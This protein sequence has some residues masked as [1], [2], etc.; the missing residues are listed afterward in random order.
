LRRL[1]LIL[2]AGCGNTAI[3]TNDLSVPMDDLSMAADL[4]VAPDLAV[5]PDLAVPAEAD[6]ATL[7]DLSVAADFAIG[8]DFSLLPDL[9]EPDLSPLADLAGPY[10][11]YVD[12][13]A[14]LDGNPGTLAL[15]FKTIGAAASHAGSGDTIRLL[16]GTW[17]SAVESGFG[18]SGVTI[19]DGVAVRAV[20]PGTVTLA[21][22]LI[23]AGGGS[24]SDL[25]FQGGTP[26]IQASAGTLTLG[27]LRFLTD[28]DAGSLQITGTAAVSLVPGAAADYG[29]VNAFAVVS[30]GASLTVTGGKLTGIVWN[31]VDA[32]PASFRTSANATLTLD[33]VTFDT[34]QV[35]AIAASGVS[36]VFTKN[37]TVI[38]NSSRPTAAAF[39]TAAVFAGGAATVDIQGT[40]IINNPAPAIRVG[41]ATAIPTI[42]VRSVS[43][44]NNN[45]Y[46]IYAPS[47]ARPPSVTLANSTFDNNANGGVILLSGTEALDVR[48]CTFIG[49]HVNQGLI[50]Y[51]D[52]SLSPTIYVRG[53][54]FTGNPDNQGVRIAGPS[55]GTYDFGTVADPGNNTFQNNNTTGLPQ[56]YLAVGGMTLINAIGNTWMPNVGGADASGHYVPT[57]GN[58][59]VESNV[60]GLPNYQLEQFG[61]GA[62]F[63]RL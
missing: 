17:N 14:G 33:G 3:T 2:V 63:I 21:G 62:C 53:S 11:F 46:G 57:G 47:F 61:G 31:S 40:Q 41:G 36:K 20:T 48:T 16:P 43:V 23:F 6:L 49:N 22:V 54:T 25:R 7:D 1:L 34:N 60:N 24:A 15:P 38:K 42:K 13:V 35:G 55:T 56:V 29:T 59:Y 52:G 45:D 4:A 19:P 30:G 8:A 39:C 10:D 50:D 12:A 5:E 18:G 32:C 44:L 58:P 37:G 9:A 51:Y 27:N 28:N 26:G